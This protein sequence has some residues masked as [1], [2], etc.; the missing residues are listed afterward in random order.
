MAPSMT[1]ILSAL[2][3]ILDASALIPD[4]V[5]L[6]YA[7]A[8]IGKRQTFTGTLGGSTP[9][10]TDT[11]DPERPYGVDGDTFTDYES[12]ASR[13][14]LLT[15]T[16]I[17]NTDQSSS[18]SLQDCQDQLNSCMSTVS[19]T[20]VALQGATIASAPTATSSTTDATTVTAQLAQ[21]TIPYDSEFDLVCDL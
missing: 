19:S 5:G 6:V 18:F 21:T 11:G 16:Q 3:L 9:A 14:S 10:V 20:S 1:L 7:P 8:S 17:A 15:R 12:A 4:P 13:R 2:F